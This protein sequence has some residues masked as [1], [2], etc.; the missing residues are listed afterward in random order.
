MSQIRELLSTTELEPRIY[1]RILLAL[2]T[3]LRRGDIEAIKV[4]DIN[5][6]KNCITTNSKKTKK[7]MA[8]RPVPLHIMQELRF[9]ADGLP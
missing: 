3:G 8:S 6:V 4:S 1:M 5:F 7:T 2:A 9:Y